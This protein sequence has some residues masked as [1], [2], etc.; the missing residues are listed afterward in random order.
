MK[1]GKNLVMVPVLENLVPSEHLPINGDENE[2]FGVTIDHCLTFTKLQ[3]DDSE[4]KH[5]KSMQQLINV[6]KCIRQGDTSQ[7]KQEEDTAPRKSN[8][9]L[10][11]STEKYTRIFESLSQTDARI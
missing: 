8:S 11:N 4:I 9:L 2:I 6:K 3:L 5:T 10:E 7:V 1:T